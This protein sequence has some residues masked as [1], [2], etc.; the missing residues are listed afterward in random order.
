[1]DSFSLEKNSA[2]DPPYFAEMENIGTFDTDESKEKDLT[3]EKE[4]CTMRNCTRKHKNHM[5]YLIHGWKELETA[6]INRNFEQIEKL[7]HII[8]KACPCLKKDI[9]FSI[10]VRASKPEHVK[11]IQEIDPKTFESATYDIRWHLPQTVAILLSN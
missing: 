1:M 3:E 6:T 2:M 5:K 9:F 7:S 8:H 10:L 11:M 4:N